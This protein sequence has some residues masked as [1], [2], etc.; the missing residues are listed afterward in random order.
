MHTPGRKPEHGSIFG[1]TYEGVVSPTVGHNHPYP[2]R[3]HG[4]IWTYPIFTRPY[5]QNPYA[6]TPYAGLGSPCA[7]SAKVG[8]SGLGTSETFGSPTGSSLLDAGIGGAIGY[9]I[10]KNPHEKTVLAAV[11]AGG[12]AVFGSL[13]LAGLVALGVY[14][15]MKGA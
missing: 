8:A 4:P 5:R 11:G 12:G 15:V 2:T 3:Y 9:L 7:C 1:D 10:G 14:R 6:L 13:G